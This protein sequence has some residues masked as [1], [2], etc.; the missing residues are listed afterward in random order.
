[1]KN[2]K[3]LNEFIKENVQEENTF[4]KTIKHDGEELQL[5]K[6]ADDPFKVQYY[7]EDEEGPYIDINKIL[8]DNMLLDAIW[9]EKGGE[10]EKIA[11][12]LDFLEKTEKTTKSGFSQFILYDII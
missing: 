8:P 12:G 1:M 7:L 6:V 4:I 3:T 10:E 2:L 9:V 11:D 5:H